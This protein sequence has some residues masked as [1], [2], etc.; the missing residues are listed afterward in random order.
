M[1]S[2]SAHAVSKSLVGVGSSSALGLVVVS[3]FAH[4]E[5]S[6]SVGLAGGL[7]GL[8]DSTPGE[9][10]TSAEELGVGS[11]AIAVPPFALAPFLP[12]PRPLPLPWL[13][14]LLMAFWTFES[15][16][17]RSTS[18]SAEAIFE[19]LDFA[20][21]AWY[22]S[23]DSSNT[24]FPSISASAAAASSFLSIWGRSASRGARSYG[25]S[26][27]KARPVAVN[28]DWGSGEDQTG[29][30]CAVLDFKN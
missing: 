1:V 10:S 21:C 20:S 28:R 13:A 12:R 5:F 9:A 8:G 11:V 16:W 25:Q 29:C 15:F 14:L 18:F 6:G 26:W 22:G 19:D 24:S 4:V 27:T 2:F 23:L 17:A 30:Y 3:G 7:L